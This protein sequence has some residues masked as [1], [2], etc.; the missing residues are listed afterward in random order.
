MYKDIRQQRPNYRSR[1]WCLILYNLNDRRRAV[2]GLGYDQCGICCH[3]QDKDHF[4]FQLHHVPVHF[5][6][7]YRFPDW[8]A[9][10]LESSRIKA[11]LVK[12]EREPHAG[13]G[14]TVRDTRLSLFCVP[15]PATRSWFDLFAE[16]ASNLA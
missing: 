14:G 12:G 1:L 2:E 15:S 8:I 13:I 5:E 10:L 11:R 4:T 16:G 9:F 3:D 6:G 7:T